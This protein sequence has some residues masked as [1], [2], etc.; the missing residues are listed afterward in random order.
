MPTNNNNDNYYDS[1]SVASVD[2][3]WGKCVIGSIDSDGY[4]GDAPLP[5]EKDII[6]QRGTQ[7]T[8]MMDSS[9]TSRTESSQP[10][11]SS[12]TRETR[13][14]KDEARGEYSFHF[15]MTLIDEGKSGQATDRTIQFLI[16]GGVVI[17]VAAAVGK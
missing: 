17:L 1:N 15:G 5:C 2:T 10:L 8:I 9:A 13:K 4:R 7:P 12:V 14:D 11:S 6:S 16:I 3:D